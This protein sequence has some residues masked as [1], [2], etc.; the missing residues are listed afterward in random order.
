MLDVAS[1]RRRDSDLAAATISGAKS[2]L[3]SRPSGPIARAAA[4]PVS[5]V[6]AASSR[7]VWPGCGANASSICSDTARD[8]SHIQ[9]RSRSH[10]AAMACQV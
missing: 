4:K 8:T 6:P 3:I 10:P 1:P 9:L 7:I 2:V 5:P